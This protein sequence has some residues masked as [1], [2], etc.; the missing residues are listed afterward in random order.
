MSNTFMSA[1][2]T[3]KP[4]IYLELSNKVDKETHIYCK[5]INE[6]LSKEFFEKMYTTQLVS[7]EGREICVKIY[8]QDNTDVKDPKVLRNRFI[9]YPFT[10]IEGSNREG[11]NRYELSEETSIFS[12]TEDSIQHCI[13]EG[14]VKEPDLHRG[15]AP[16]N[17]KTLLNVLENYMNESN[18]T[19][20]FEKQFIGMIHTSRKDF[21]DLETQEGKDLEGPDLSHLDLRSLKE[22]HHLTL[23]NRTIVGADFSGC[24][25]EHCCFINTRF[26]NCNF[27]NSTITHCNLGGNKVSFYSSSVNNATFKDN[28]H[29]NLEDEKGSPS[30][31]V[32]TLSQYQEKLQALG[33]LHTSNL[34]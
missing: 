19:K 4:S 14:I 7:L 23:T 11:Y 2:L 33:A 18:R 12:M 32:K 9:F 26:M 31:P 22:I 17:T 20:D 30:I 24:T 13:Q 1:V 25:I 8:P 21:L 16:T 3:Q 28:I 15:L 10:K 34:K 5:T 29:F 6:V 27:E